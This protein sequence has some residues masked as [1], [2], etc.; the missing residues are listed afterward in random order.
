[1]R[2]SVKVRATRLR[3]VTVLAIGTVCGLSAAALGDLVRLDAVLDTRCQ[4]FV[5]GEPVSFDQ[6]FEEL[7]VTS[8]DLP[9]RVASRLRLPTADESLAA[10]AMG[11]ADLFEP[12]LGVPGRNPAELALEADLFSIDPDTSYQVTAS[13][14][15]LRTIEFTQAE[16]LLEDASEQDVVGG[17][18]LSGAIIVW[19]EDDLRDLDGLAAEMTFTVEHIRTA[20][21]PEQAEPVEQR[22]TV[23]TAALGVA[24]KADGTVEPFAEGE[25][26]T[27]FGGSELVRQLAGTD[28]D[29]G[30]DQMG[31]VWVLLV[32]AQELSYQYSA[33]PREEFQLLASFN[34][35]VANLPG[36]T[37][38]SAVFGRDFEALGELVNEAFDGLD[39]E[40][41]QTAVNL[42]Q[43]KARV[44]ADAD[45]TTA[46]TTPGSAQRPMFCGGLGAEAL[47]MLL[48][49]ALLPAATMRRR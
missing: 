1:L 13:V 41:T 30:L 10:T 8:A 39:G 48:L 23:F 27:L 40:A 21:D 49:A 29:D 42:A 35:D 9:L 46:I 14:Q 17:V 7:E 25:V 6:A 34:V 31:T 45:E 4:E 16:L 33:R 24:G 28:A 15:E 32:P 22:D 37:G 12:K 5:A 19:A 18:F 43:A 36:G 38:V 2:G 47:G 11:F 20:D 26:A 44:P 3:H